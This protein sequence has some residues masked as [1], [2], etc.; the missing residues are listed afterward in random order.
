MFGARMV[1]T[2]EC[3]F[4]FMHAEVDSSVIGLN[5]KYLTAKIRQFVDLE[6]LFPLVTLCGII[7]LHILS[8][9]VSSVYI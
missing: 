2:N 9:L 6:S 1:N 5:N 3:V 8:S 4:I 7:F